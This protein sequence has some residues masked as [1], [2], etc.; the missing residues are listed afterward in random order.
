MLV[1]RRICKFI[2]RVVVRLRGVGGGRG[3]FFCK[4]F[5]KVMFF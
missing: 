5:F 2:K 3:G 1:E 4:Y